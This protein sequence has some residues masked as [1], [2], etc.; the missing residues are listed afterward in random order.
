M[1]QSM[2][3]SSRPGQP[4][5]SPPQGPPGHGQAHVADVGSSWTLR[6]RT[7]P[8]PPEFNKS[9]KAIPVRLETKVGKQSGVPYHLVF[10]K[11]VEGESDGY[12][13][14]N[15]MISEAANAQWRAHEFFDGIGYPFKSWDP[16]FNNDAKAVMQFLIEKG[17][18]VLI[19]IG[20]QTQED[21]SRYRK[22]SSIQPYKDKQSWDSRGRSTP[23]ETTDPNADDE[24]PF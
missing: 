5:M 13:R 16:R 7:D 11:V 18:P 14:L 9:Y 21:G 17:D 22:I 1:N 23:N 19:G 10:F 8:K 20:M 12:D 15:F 4:S 24:I 6:E 3:Q 2:H